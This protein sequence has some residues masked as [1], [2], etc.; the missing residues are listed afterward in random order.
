MR[1]LLV[2]LAVLFTT[3]GSLTSAAE[4]ERLKHNNP[5]LV[6][7][8]GVGLWAW[9]VPADADGDGDNDLIVVCPDVP[10]NGTYLFENTA[11]KVKMPVFKPGKKLSNGAFQVTPS[12]I[13]EEAGKT[14]VRVMTPGNEYPD[15][16]RTGLAT[17][18]KLP[19]TVNVHGSK[20]RFNQ[21]RYV[22]YNGDGALDLTIGIEDWADY[23]WDRAFNEQGKWTRG[24]LHGH[25]YL[26][27]NRGTTEKPDYA[28]PVKMQAAGKVLDTFGCPSQSFADFDGDGDLDL[29]CG[30]FLDGFTYFSN[31]GTRQEPEYAAGQRIMHQGKPLLMDL[32]MLIVVPFDWD[33]DGDADLIVGQE[34]G[35]V[36]LVENVTQKKGSVPEFAQPQFFQQEADE[37]KFGVLCTP[38]GFD[39]DGDGDEDIVSGNSAGYIGWIE[40]L[41]AASKTSL[42]K[43]AAPKM[44]EVDGEV[45][46]IQAGTNGSIQGPAEAKWGY[47]TISVA[48]W[49]HDGLPDIVANSILGRVVWWKNIGSR[50][51]PKLGKMRSVQ[52]EWP[53]TPPKP[54]WTWWNPAAKELATEWRTTPL[55]HDF[56]GDGLNDL[57]M[58]D[59]EGY[60]ALF[61][62]AS[63]KDQANPSFPFNSL[64]LLPPQ[65]NFYGIGGSE[66]DGAGKKLNKADGLLRLNVGE[67]GKSGRRK[68]TVADWDGDGLVDLITN[69]RNATFFKCLKSTK[70]RIELQD[71]RALDER[72]LAGHDTSP[73]TVDWNGDG[74]RDLLVGAEDGFLYFKLNE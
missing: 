31:I 18:R 49:D 55:V 2:C 65:R 24:P 20:I 12:Y 26:R 68:L 32:Q 16:L 8:L 30:E 56:T 23:G 28:E 53:S 3:L 11:G 37:V 73:T 69:G 54:A 15:F 71:T 51:A 40:N 44:F 60:F 41:G 21:W 67:A 47:T 61:P 22:D 17:P 33:Q 14:T 45:I 50:Q 74:R 62:R 7:D 13:T 29:I 57:A 59:H 64:V 10:Y 27:L 35:R 9:P 70:D 52:V 72:Q 48:D 46:R 38:V 58:L 25:I 6:V 1:A 36:A 42:P 5:G 66:F 4:L 63:V 43:F 39:W 19:L 34:D